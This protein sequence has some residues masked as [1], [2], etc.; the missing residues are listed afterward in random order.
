MTDLIE[1]ARSLAAKAEKKLKEGK[2][3]DAEVAELD[4][5]CLH[6]MRKLY[7]DGVPLQGEETVKIALNLSDEDFWRGESGL[8]N[9]GRKEPAETRETIAWRTRGSTN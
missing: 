4:G 1:R 5:I 8:S 7:A 9:G 6:L 2:E 3:V